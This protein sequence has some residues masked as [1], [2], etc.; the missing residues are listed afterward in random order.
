MKISNNQKTDRVGVQIVGERFELA[1]YIFREQT[2]SDYGIDAQI[3]VVDG[4][5][6]TGKLI[7]L[8]IKSGISWFKEESEE[9]YIYRGDI[10]HLDYWLEH[11][12][13][14]L[15]VLCD[16]DNKKCFWQSVTPA[17]ITYTK[18]AWKTTI[19]KYQQIN[20]GMYVDLQ[21]LINK[22][23]I[24]KSYT[25]RS[26]KDLSYGVAKRY[27]LRIIL[28]KEHTQSE[29][30]DHIK[31]ITSEAINTDYHR[32]DLTRNHWRNKPA[33]VIWLDI[34]PSSEDEQNNNNICQT[35]WFSKNLDSMY[36][37]LSNNGRGNFRKSKSTMEQ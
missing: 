32:S 18:K 16:I 17:N 12:L 23:T 2:V 6:V 11:S 13:P 26:I 4:D 15:I 34:F 3:E 33:H 21:Y 27:C 35:K 7:A 25:V 9:G 24:Y 20:A 29:I 22:L 14:V 37:P 5:I 30:V 19:P 10:E 28:N 36:F 31:S 1:G 8:Q